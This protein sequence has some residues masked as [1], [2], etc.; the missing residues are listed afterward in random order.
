MNI[1]HFIFDLDG[2]LWNTTEVSAAA[3]THALR[4]DGRSQLCVTPDMIKQEFGKTLRA[5][6][7]DLFP[8]F[9]RDIRDELM[10]K[11]SDAN[12]QFLRNTNCPM[13]YPD[14]TK[15]LA[16]L[17]QRSKLYI[18]SNCQC[19]YIEL[20]LD[21]YDLNPYFTDIEC[22]GTNLKSKAEN[23][24][25]LMERNQILD[26]VYVGDTAGDYQS[27]VQAEIPFIFAA[28][29]YGSVPQS[30]C[31]INRFSDLLHITSL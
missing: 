24:R 9:H 14:V 13:L 22:Y 19:G 12:I 2:T 16:Q 30:T 26:A 21:K 29:G 4:E 20:F 18:V 27:S 23:I 28:Y 3:Y 6:A 10:E 1:K 31:R 17:S 25:I 11:C 7:D 15:T 8:Q 5:I